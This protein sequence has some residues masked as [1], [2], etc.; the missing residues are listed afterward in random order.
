M[1]YVIN[2]FFILI[3]LSL[4]ICTYAAEEAKIKII[5]KQILASGFMPVRL[6]YQNP[7]E[8][9]AKIIQKIDAEIKEL[10]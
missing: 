6:L 4:P 10:I 1:R 3:F 8:D 5:K 9:L 7:D 2:K